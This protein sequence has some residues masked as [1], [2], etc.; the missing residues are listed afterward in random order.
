MRWTHFSNPAT[1]D[2]FYIVGG[3]LGDRWTF[4]ESF[5]DRK[6]A[7]QEARRAREWS[8]RHGEEDT[9]RVMTRD[10]ELVKDFAV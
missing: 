7:L 8:R 9:I 1:S 6:E 2:G 10:G 4:S 5:D 3:I